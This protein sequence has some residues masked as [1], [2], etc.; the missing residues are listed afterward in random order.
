MGIDP[1]RNPHRRGDRWMLTTVAAILV[2]PRYT[3]RQ[4]WNR[5]PSDHDALHADEGSVERQHDVQRRAAASGW[6]I[7]QEL[8]HPPLVSEEQVVAVQAVQVETQDLPQP[9][10]L[11]DTM[12]RRSRHESDG[13]PQGIEVAAEGVRVVGHT[14][15]LGMPLQHCQRGPRSRGA[16]WQVELSGVAEGGELDGHAGLSGH[17]Q[18]GYLLDTTGLDETGR[19]AMPRAARRFGVEAARQGAA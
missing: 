10:P 6:V 7:S 9:R 12:G 11:G 2:S 4:V 5:E 16:Q 1:A 8:A 13:G 14:D 17:D 15:A 3:G 19:P 18:V